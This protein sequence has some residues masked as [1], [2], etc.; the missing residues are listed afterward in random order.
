[1]STISKV[2]KTALTAYGKVGTDWVRMTAAR[3]TFEDGSDGTYFV[4][5]DGSNAILP[6]LPSM[7]RTSGD[8]ANVAAKLGHRVDFAAIPSV[9]LENH[10]WKPV[11]SLQ[12]IGDKFGVDTLPIVLSY[13]PQA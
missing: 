11:Y 5:A 8:L 4:R 6:T 13:E 7:F 12:G 3:V 9:G 10:A 1:M 2:T